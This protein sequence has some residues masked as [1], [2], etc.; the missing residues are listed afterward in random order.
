MKQRRVLAGIE[1]ASLRRVVEHLLSDG[2][3]LPPVQFASGARQFH[4]EAA[5]VDVIVAEYELFGQD[6][7]S[8]I[9]SLREVNPGARLV[10][11][12]PFT[13]RRPNRRDLDVDACLPTSAI[14]SRLAD[15]VRELVRRGARRMGRVQQR[16]GGAV[17]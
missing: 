11:I 10:L 13:W 3:G 1:T 8:M 15:T 4:R 16:P 7:D 17:H 12:V 6:P 9:R 14:A 2:E 5:G